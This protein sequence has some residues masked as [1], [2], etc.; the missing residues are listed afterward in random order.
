[1]SAQPAQLPAGQTTPR[2]LTRP[3]CPP[4]RLPPVPQAYAPRY[5]SPKEE[6]W[7]FLVADN[8]S[9]GFGGG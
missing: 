9:V 4:A 1:M 6:A 7:Y 2:L 5:P 3:L 8:S